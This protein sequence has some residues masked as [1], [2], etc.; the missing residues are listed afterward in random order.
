MPQ[1]DFSKGNNSHWMRHQAILDTG[2]NITALQL[3]IES[4]VVLKGIKTPPLEFTYL[5]V[6]ISL[7]IIPATQEE[8]VVNPNAG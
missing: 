6:A 4:F 1:N 3:L 2:L 5:G 8:R 7:K